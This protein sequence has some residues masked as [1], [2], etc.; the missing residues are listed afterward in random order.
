MALPVTVAAAAPS[1]L[2]SD[3]IRSGDWKAT[4]DTSIPM[5]PTA[6]QEIVNLALDPDV[7]VAAIVTVVSRDPVLATRV[8]QLANSAFVASSREVSSIQEAVVRVGTGLVRTV[9]TSTCMNALAADPHIYGTQGRVCVDHCLGTAYAAWLVAGSAGEPPAEA[10]LYG[11]LHDVGKLL[12]IKLAHQSRQ[13][14]VAAPG[15]EEFAEVMADQHASLGG[16]LLQQWGL[17]SRLYDPI[18]WHHWPEQAP[19]RPRAAAVAYAAN[20]LAHRF[21]FACP[22]DEFDPLA[23]PLFEALGIDAAVL[24]RLDL[25]VPELFQLARKIR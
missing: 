7:S 17:P 22:V 6:A 25:Q 15:E 2:W 11:L 10:F 16:F 24:A 20:R 1:A 4:A 21:G 9:M 19:E 14:G 13:Y 18:V 5:L 12:L 3:W 23:D 8:I